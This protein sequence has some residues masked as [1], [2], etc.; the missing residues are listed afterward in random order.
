M[1][2]GVQFLGQIGGPVQCRLQVFQDS[3][4]D[5]AHGPADGNGLWCA[6]CLMILGE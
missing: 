6:T 3:P 5:M 4:D 2:P 1:G